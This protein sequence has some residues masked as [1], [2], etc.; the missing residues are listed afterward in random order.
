M[1]KTVL[2]IQGAGA[3][4]EDKKLA[5]NLS[6]ALGTG[7][8]VHY[9]AMPNED[10]PDYAEWQAQVNQ[11]LNSLEGEIIL[12]GHSLGGSMLL[13]YLVEEQSQKRFS[14]LVVLATPFWKMDEYALP[15]NFAAELPKELPLFFYHN[16]DDAIVRIEHLARYAEKLPTA[17]IRRFAT[18]GHQFDNDLAAVAEDIKSLQ[19]A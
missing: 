3:Y 18:G 19:E 1:T 16:E 9:P 15:E 7:Y 14:G 2:F 12:V 8:R 10:R 4:A 11:A 17:T 5:N 13:N 6:Q